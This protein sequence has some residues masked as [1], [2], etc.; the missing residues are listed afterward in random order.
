[1]EEAIH[2]QSKIAWK[3]TATAEGLRSLS[4][5][6]EVGPARKFPLLAFTA[7]TGR[8]YHLKQKLAPK[9]IF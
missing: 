3:L 9:D 4:Q 7:G 2:F 1:M 5:S 8:H 6:N